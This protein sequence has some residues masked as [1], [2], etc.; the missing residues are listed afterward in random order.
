[1]LVA[2]AFVYVLAVVAG[3]CF[4]VHR[5]WVSVQ[6]IFLLPSTLGL[7]LL[8]CLTVMTY[9]LRHDFPTISTACAGQASLRAI[10]GLLSC[11]LS[12]TLAAVLADEV[13]RQH[14]PLYNSL[15]IMEL[16]F[17]LLLPLSGSLALIIL[18]VFLTSGLIRNLSHSANS[19]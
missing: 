16:V 7:M 14:D 9:P 18:Y 15:I 1:M 4:L 11:F 17:V 12:L 2:F 10:L 3:V 19:V 6:L 13:Q 5:S 8:L